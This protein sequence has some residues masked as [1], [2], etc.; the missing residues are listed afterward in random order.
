MK[1]ERSRAWTLA[2][3]LLAI[4]TSLRAGAPQKSAPAL[5]PRVEACLQQGREA[6]AKRHFKDAEKAFSKANK[7]EHER[8]LPCWV[9]LAMVQGEEGDLD[10]ALR[11][12]DKALATATDNAARAEVRALR[13]DILLAMG[14]KSL[15]EAEA[16]YRAA[17]ALDPA[18]PEYHWRVAIA[19]FKESRDPEG[20]QEL[21]RCL[22]LAPNGPLAARARKLLANPDRARES[23]AVDFRITTVQ[24]QELSLQGLIG[25][26]V[27][28]DF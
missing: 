12:A 17:V 4:A 11:T 21:N 27:V 14:A 22:A 26:I 5:D 6:L 2:A 9:G 13:G 18:E 15:K 8:C 16:E 10:G 24:G 23:Y 28:L 7:I 1:S 20:K 3:L 25:E 19:L